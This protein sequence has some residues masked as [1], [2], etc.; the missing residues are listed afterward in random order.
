MLDKFLHNLG[1]RN[2]Q[3]GIWIS[4]LYGS[5]K[6]HLAKMLRT[7]CTDYKFMDGASARS[8]AKLPD[9][10]AKHLKELSIQGKR[11]R[12]GQRAAAQV[13]PWRPGGGRGGYPWRYHR[14]GTQRS[15]TC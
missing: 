13:G 3:P 1:S 4:G 9:T 7:L 12:T 5:G 10:V 8:I 11:Q 2:E 14:T 15:H 6:S